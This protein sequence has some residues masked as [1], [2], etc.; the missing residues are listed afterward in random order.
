M[1]P[2]QSQGMRVALLAPLLTAAWSAPPPQAPS[3]KPAATPIV[4]SDATAELGLTYSARCGGPEKLDI[5]E[6]NGVGAGVLD[7][8]LDGD[9]DL[10][11]AQGS[12]L[13]E[14]N[15][16]GGAHPS[17]WRNDGGRFV[18]SSADVGLRGEAA[19]KLKGWWTCV[20][21]GDPNGDG[22]PDIFLGG[23]LKSAF[24]VNSHAQGRQVQL[25]DRARE[26]GIDERGWVSN[27]C[28]LDG[29]GDGDQDLYLVRYLELDPKRPPRRV[30]GSL[31]VPCTWRGQEVYCGPKGLVPTPDRYFKN[32]G[33]EFT[34]AT[35]E[36]GFSGAPASYGL[37]IC[38][39]DFDADGDLDLYVANDSK[40]NFLWRH[41]ADGFVECAFETGVGL[42]EDGSTYAGMGVAAGDVN[43]DGLPD[44]VVTNFTDEPV[45]L[46][47]SRAASYGV[48]KKP[49]LYDTATWT[50]GIGRATLATLKWGV[51]LEDL[52]LDGDLDVFVMNGHV[53]P[54]ADAKGT[55][56]SYAQR[57]QVFVNS[58]AG[59]FEELVPPSGSPLL[60][61]RS[62]RI[63]AALDL[64]DDGDE[65][66]LLV[67]V[68]GP[69][70]L[71][72]N[73]TATPASG[74]AHRV[75]IECLLPPREPGL[76]PR[77]A[78]GAQVTVITPSG[79]QVREVRRSGS[80]ASSR[81]PRLCFGLGSS[82]EIQQ[83]EI[84][85]PD[86]TRDVVPGSGLAGRAVRIVQGKPVS[87]SSTPLSE[88]GSNK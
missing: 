38:P 25:T 60:E 84:R 52:D 65:D 53:Y 20:T 16:G 21:V 26:M 80:Y 86:G 33:G 79:R 58:G 19:A 6:A 2:V 17:Y 73:G 59:K 43:G 14:L 64:D 28:F 82:P 55:G 37:G 27:A 39:V 78:L 88:G 8:D 22:I 77:D 46:Y 34:E 56:T 40:Q 49:V 69:A 66:F 68:D 47:T 50:S 83:I 70:A 3:S 72:R 5:V 61:R 75:R 18:D 24:L 85:W 71:L 12:S 31:K 30:A 44:L 13:E 74:G 54:Q 51:E 7:A 87:V 41:D 23:Y 1:G 45:S 35:L 36:A 63:L 76:A 81:D 62:H 57:N 48:P 11:F 32:E 67:P 4:F 9:L 10:F 42:G 15:A 29:D